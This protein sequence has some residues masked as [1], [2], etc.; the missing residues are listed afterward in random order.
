MST[1]QRLLRI[2]ACIA[3]CFL[4]PACK[5]E[6]KEKTPEQGRDLRPLGYFV[7][8][9]LPGEPSPWKPIDGGKEHVVVVVGV[10]GP[11]LK[12]SEQNPEEAKAET[13]TGADLSK[14]YG[15]SPRQFFLIMPDGRQ[16]PGELIERLGS[17]QH[18]FQNGYTGSYYDR[19]DDGEV[20][21]M[22]FAV[23]WVLSP[24]EWKP[25]LRIKFLDKAEAKVP[26]KRYEYPAVYNEKFSV[27]MS[28]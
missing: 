12:K 25:P 3:L 14:L 6:P 26:D 28:K 20:I 24:H 15:A 10:P 27:H 9:E 19:P 13:K 18:R 4:L 23:A 11:W 7:T 17:N 21:E 5:V 1:S 8:A 2:A 16:L 22:T